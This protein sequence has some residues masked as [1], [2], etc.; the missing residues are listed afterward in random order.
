M[1]AGIEN[2]ASDW[3]CMHG[4]DPENSSHMSMLQ[5]GPLRP[6][7]RMFLPINDN[8]K[9]KKPIFMHGTAVECPVIKPFGH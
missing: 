5:Q 2:Q 1:N 9:R 7:C 4:V 8:G 3:P 6:N